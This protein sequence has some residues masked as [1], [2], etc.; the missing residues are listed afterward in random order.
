MQHMID[1]IVFPGALKGQ[2]IAGVF[3][4]ADEGGIPP[5]SR[6]DGAKLAFGKI[7]TDR[8]LFD[9]ALGFQNGGGKF[10]GLVLRQIQ[11]QMEGHGQF[12][13]SQV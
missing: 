12:Y 10:L 7:S 11:D 6:A 1:S 2:Y 8:A 4:H 3:H 9:L 13:D 5:F